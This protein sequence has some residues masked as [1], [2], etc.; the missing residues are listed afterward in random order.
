VP[1]PFAQAGGKIWTTRHEY[2]PKNTCQVVAQTMPSGKMP[3]AEAAGDR[4]SGG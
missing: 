3:Q 1:P 4:R 2:L